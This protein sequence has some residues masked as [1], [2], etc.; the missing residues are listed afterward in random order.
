MP[1]WLCHALIWAGALSWVCCGEAC[2]RLILLDKRM[3][4]WRKAAFA[5]MLGPLLLP[6]AIHVD[7][8]ERKTGDRR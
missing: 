1:D 6:A 2:T 8:R 3:T 5:I 4:D 7:A